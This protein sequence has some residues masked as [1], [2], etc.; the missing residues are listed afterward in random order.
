MVKLFA[1]YFGSEGEVHDVVKPDYNMLL[2]VDTEQ[3]SQRKL[4][5]KQ[6]EIDDLYIEVQ[7]ATVF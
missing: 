7:T 5:F 2:D 4:D 3:N 1:P 6:I